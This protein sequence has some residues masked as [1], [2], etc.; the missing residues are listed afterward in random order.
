MKNG[1]RA[2]PEL[3]SDIKKEWNKIM[4]DHF[5]DTKNFIEKH[6]LMDGHV[7]VLVSSGLLMQLRMLYGTETGAV[8]Y[9]IN[10]LNNLTLSLAVEVEKELQKMGMK[11]REE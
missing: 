2:L 7:D 3:S 1:M 11:K 9:Q 4:T 5:M 6:K 8:I 10:E